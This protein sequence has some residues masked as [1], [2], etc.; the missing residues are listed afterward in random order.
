MAKVKEQSRFRSMDECKNFVRREVLRQLKAF[1]T[2]EIDNVIKTAEVTVRKRANDFVTEIQ[3][4]MLRT[5]EFAEQQQ[6]VMVAAAPEP[7]PEPEPDEFAGP[8]D[9]FSDVGQA[10]M[11][12]LGDDPM[13]AFLPPGAPFPWDPLLAQLV[14][15]DQGCGVSV[16]PDSGYCTHSLDGSGSGSWGGASHLS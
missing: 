13:Y 5:C 2:V 16:A 10:V 9:L 11:D 8:P 15:S 3:A 12:S 4:K 14:D 7:T 6:V 1:L